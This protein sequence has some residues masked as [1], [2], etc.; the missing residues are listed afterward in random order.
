MPRSARTEDPTPHAWLA[1]VFGR[2]MAAYVWLVART[3]RVSGPPITQEQTIF[4]IWHE[5]NLVSAIVAWKLRRDKH[6]VVFST[7]GFRGIVMNTM[8]RSLRADVV[9]LPEE[10]S[11]TRGEATSLSREMARLGREG[12]SLVVSCDGPFG[13]FRVVKPGVL[14][15]ARESGLPI[16]PWAIASRPPFRLE[17]RWDRMILALPFGRLRVYEGQAIR[18]GERERVKPRLAELQAELE[19]I[20]SLADARMGG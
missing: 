17:R 2:C 5:S 15:V 8:L 14:I 19:R 18:V 4:A 1:R 16:Q 3:C 13:P 6:P 11:S 10:G 7:R 20:Q 9:T 12:R